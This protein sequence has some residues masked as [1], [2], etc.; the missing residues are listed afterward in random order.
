MP[1][2]HSGDA[3]EVPATLYLTSK[4]YAAIT[5][6]EAGSTVRCRWG[7]PDMGRAVIS[8]SKEDIAAGVALA[9]YVLM[10]Y[11]LAGACGSHSRHWQYRN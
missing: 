8:L 2:G 11:F 1:R 6:D 5:Q 4:S 10:L 3:P 7:K 9:L